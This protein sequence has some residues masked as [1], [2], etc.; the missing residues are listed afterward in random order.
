MVKPWNVYKNTKN[1]C[2]FRSGECMTQ[3]DSIAFNHTELSADGVAY[4]ETLYEQYLQDKNSVD[5]TGSRILKNTSKPM[6]HRTMPSKSSFCCL[7]AISRAVCCL[8]AWAIVP[9]LSKWRYSSWF[10]PI[11]VVGT[12]RQIWIRSDCIHV[13]WLR[14]WLCSFM[15]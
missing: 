8:P 15:G 6:T 3:K 2:N 13:R 4:I 5:A 14:I 10:Q 11:A 12:A 9:I 7:R 1:D